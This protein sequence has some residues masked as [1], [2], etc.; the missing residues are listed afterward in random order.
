MPRSPHRL[1]II[2]GKGGVG[3]T[4]IAMALTK[5]LESQGVNVKYN[6]FYQTPEKILWDH[7]QLPVL[8]TELFSSAE[9][10]IAKKLKS[11][12]IASWIMKTHFFRSLFQMIPGMGHMILLGR[13]IEELQNDP[14]LT[15]VM[16]SPAS[17]HALTMFESSSNFKNIFGKGLIVKDIERMQSFLSQPGCLKTIIIALATELAISEAND[18]KSELENNTHGMVMN[19]DIIINDSFVRYMEK[20]KISDSDLPDF[21]KQKMDLE[22]SVLKDMPALPHLDNNQQEKV[23][24]ELIPLVEELI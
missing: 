1:Y 19:S 3:K 13:I 4:A 7:L 9:M 8:D 12:T 2:T 16:D 5:K 11:T 20:E 17:G 21:L 10:Y 18:L 22:K 6:C 15:I 14:S 23:I 24:E